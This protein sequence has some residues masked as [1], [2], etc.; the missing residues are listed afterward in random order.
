MHM[1]PCLNAFNLPHLYDVPTHTYTHTFLHTP[2]LPCT[3][4]SLSQ[5]PTVTVRLTL[6]ITLSGWRQPLP[7]AGAEMDRKLWGWGLCCT[8]SRHG[9]RGLGREHHASEGCR[10]ERDGFSSV[11]WAVVAPWGEAESLDRGDTGRGGFKG[12]LRWILG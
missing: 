10:R 12:G 8:S 1:A 11:G 5:T 9:P 6:I 2:S 3:C 4:R 7:G